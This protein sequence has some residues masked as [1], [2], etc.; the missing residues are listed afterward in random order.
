MDEI[1]YHQPGIKPSQQRP[2]E[3]T[4]PGCAPPG[5][6]P[7]TR[8]AYD[9][10]GLG[11]CIFALFTQAGF[12]PSRCRVGQAHKGNPPPP[13]R[14]SD[15]GGIF[16]TGSRVV[17]IWPA[18]PPRED[19]GDGMGA[20][21]W[22]WSWCLWTKQPTTFRPIRLLVLAEGQA[23]CTAPLVQCIDRSGGP[24]PHLLSLVAPLRA[25]PVRVRSCGSVAGKVK[26][27]SRKSWRQL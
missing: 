23:R 6:Q 24:H 4:H 7:P 19:N 11:H 26:R 2:P 3:V 18:R 22:S 8:C 20:C 15:R 16:L 14:R 10:R 1:L 12:P 27:C 21:P 25:L 13:L 9:Y 5:S 17:W